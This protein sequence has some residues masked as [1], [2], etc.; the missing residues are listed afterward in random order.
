MFPT[1]VT[2]SQLRTQGWLAIA[3][4]TGQQCLAPWKLAFLLEKRKESNISNILNRKQYKHPSFS[5]MLILW[6]NALVMLVVK[7]MF[8]LP[9]FMG[10][11]VLRYWLLSTMGRLLMNYVYRLSVRP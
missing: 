7:V 3:W 4:V 6:E 9:A 10:S 5:A 2:G 8:H 1:R 11:G